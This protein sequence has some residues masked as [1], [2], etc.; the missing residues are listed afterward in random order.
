[1]ADTAPQVKVPR[2]KLYKM[3]SYKGKSGGVKKYTPL[4]AAD[5]VG[6]ME[7]DIGNGFKALTAGLNSL[8]AS[9]NSIALSVESMTTSIK[10]SVGK[11]IKNTQT[12]VK[13]QKEALL[14][15]KT[16]EKNK[17]KEEARRRK[18]AERDEAEDSSEKPG[19]F[20]KISESFKENTKKAAGGLFS[21]LLRLAK[22]FFGAIVAF[23]VLDWLTK[24]PEK[25]QALAKTL[26]AFGKLVYK[27]TSFLAGS[28]LDGLIK[29]L[30]NPISIQGFLGAVQFIVSAAPI[31]IGMAFLK[32]PIG[33]IRAFSWVI[34][35]LGKS[36][37]G[38]FKAG[39]GL[40]KLRSFSVISLLRLACH[41]V[42]DSVPQPSCRQAEAQQLNLLERE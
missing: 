22:F 2:A 33:T 15:E 8:G 27:I 25:I 1:M 18:K 20:K 38:M 5:Q 32:N 16:R 3:I 21:G 7:S 40:G 9:L 11:Q 42:L 4:T 37:M 36:I 28:A 29:F 41:W 31:F 26:F 6:K 12:I 24:N 17:V 13:V 30:E 10:T 14:E 34:S 35:T 39:K 23:G 19:L